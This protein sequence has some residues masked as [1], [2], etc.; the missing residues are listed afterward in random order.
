MN[1]M[2]PYITNFVIVPASGNAFGSL[3]EISC[4]SNEIFVNGARI[5]DIQII[6][7]ITASNLGISGAIVTTAV[8]V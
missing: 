4:N 6:D 1:L 3:L 7:S 5:S 8:G 2:T